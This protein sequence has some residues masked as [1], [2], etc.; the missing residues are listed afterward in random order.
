MNKRIIA[1]TMG[2]AAGIGPEI[3]LKTFQGA[4]TERVNLLVIGDLA[5]MREVA[6]RLEINGLEFN[7]IASLDEAKWQKHMVNVWDMQ[8]LKPGDFLVG[9]V[10]A[11]VGD[12]AFKYIIEGIRLAKEGS[13]AAVVTAP[14]NKESIQSAGHHFAGH[15]EIF[16]EYTGTANYAMLLYDKKFSVIH[17]STHIPLMD[18][19]TTL[20]QQ[21]IERV[22][23]LA[24]D[25]MQL[26]L[27]RSPRI[28]V[29]GLN[30]HAGE[31]GLFGRQE[32]DIIKPAIDNMRSKGLNVTGPHAPDTIFLRTVQGHHDIVVAMYHDQGHIP[33]K[34][35]GFDSGVNVSV[36]M[37]IIRTSVDHGTAFDIAW[38]G[39]AKND[40][41]LQ[42]IY[43]AEKLSNPQGFQ[44]RLSHL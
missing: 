24:E 7:S 17:V 5:V 44:N 39:I 4:E 8:L 38:K 27:G 34:L 3:I 10:S 1:I 16:A 41:L 18:A 36:G 15:T 22:I 31:N 19:I 28:A 30:P 26:I 11:K 43:L 12:A 25:S 32:I 40:S 42:A 20:N 21:R 14:I 6:K 33:M 2:D 23:Q 35:L 9:Q 37:P 29:A 13:I